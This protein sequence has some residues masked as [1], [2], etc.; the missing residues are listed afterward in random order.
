METTM[1]IARWQ[2]DNG[3]IA[4]GSLDGGRLQP[5][6][7]PAAAL[8]DAVAIATDPTAATPAG[9]AVDLAAVQL[10]SP[11]PSP[12]SIRDF[13]AFEEHVA[14]ARR[15]KGLDVPELWYEIPTFYF[16]NP[17]VVHGPD[18]EI[19]IPS[20][21]ALDYELEVAAIVGRE[22]R[23]ISA[24]EAAEAIVGYTIFNDWSARDVQFREM[25][26][27]LGPAKGKDFAHTIGPVIATPEELPGEPGR[28]TGSMLA[29]VNGTL[30]SEGRLEDIHFSFAELLAHA[31]RDSVVRAG[32]VIGSGTVGS[33]CLLEL[34]ATIGDDERP[35]LQ[36]GDE[37]VLEVDGIGRLTNR[38]ARK[39]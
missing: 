16:T 3:T 32:D 21:K 29:W 25:A 14:T 33:G 26:L 22:C 28:P 30:Y 20:T 6:Q 5:L 1:L 11:V 36:D 24:E 2:D 39:H 35:W 19:A 31:A 13:M 38:I 17:A 27:Q 18:E 8:G 10:L 4:A 23:N 9:D 37:V 7:A 15:S 12:P 34:R